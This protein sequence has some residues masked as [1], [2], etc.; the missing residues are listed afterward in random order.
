MPTKIKFAT[1]KTIKQPV[2][3]LILEAPQEQDHV[4]G[5]SGP[6]FEVLVKD[7]QWHDYLPNFELQRNRFGDTFMCVSYSL[8]NVH[9]TLAKRLFDEVF[10]KSDLFLGVGSGTVRGRGNSLRQVADWN[11]L[12]G[13]VLESDYPYLTD[14]T[15]DEAYKALSRDL[16]VKALKQLDIFSFGYKWLPDNSNISLVNGLKMSPIQ[17]AVSGS[18][19]M[20]RNNYVI[21]D[22]YNPAYN[23]AV[24]ILG[25]EDGKCWHVFDSETEQMVKFAW[26]YPFA[27]PMIHALKKNMKIQLYKKMG[28]AGIAIK[29]VSE[30]SMIV[31]S[32]GSVEGGALFLSLYGVQSFKEIPLTEVKEW[33]FPVRHMI[34]TNPIRT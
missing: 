29:H 19:K 13:F 24:I 16:L 14:T 21:W 23:H 31:F 4:L 27:S 25:Y 6:E 8:N 3:G 34:N 11:R 1:A 2:G 15:L 22:R 5:A 10:N 30:P 7:G 18:Y 17:V 28:Q 12:N 20:D 9:E 33:P 32:G 26:D